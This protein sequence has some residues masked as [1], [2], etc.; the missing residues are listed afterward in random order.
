MGFDVE[1][2]TFEDCKKRLKEDKFYNKGEIHEY[3]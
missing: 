2:I 3:T 1:N